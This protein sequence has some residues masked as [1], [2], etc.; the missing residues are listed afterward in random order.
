MTNRRSFFRLAARATL[1]TGF[2]TL[3]EKL[4][5]TGPRLPSSPLNAFPQAVSSGTDGITY[6]L[7]LGI[8]GYTFAQLDILTAISM[9]QRLGVTRLSLK[10]NLL[11]LDASVETATAVVTQLKAAGI[12]VYAVGVIYMKTEAE[13]VRAFDY[14]A[15]VGVSLIIAAPDYSL[16]SS[17][18]GKV[19]ATG[20]RVALHNHGPGDRLYP[21][22]GDAWNKIKGMDKGMGLCMDIG[23]AMRAGANLTEAVSLY[24][25]RLFDMHIKD[26][27]GA[28]KEAAAI[29]MGRGVID[30]PALVR[31]L[32]KIRYTGMC[33]IEFEKDMKDPMPGL[34]ESV[35][36]FRGV[37]RTV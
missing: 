25:S 13:V 21:S 30:F 32:E 37:M 22:P 16:L 7:Q 17:V 27:T 24:K 2:Y 35:G 5:V 11:P 20:I 4:S 12:T 36:F 18:E 23:H 34:A 6:P 1:A 14:A 28:F 9:M 8:A 10:D 33:S 15:K 19:K 26:V 29:E 31:A 3:T